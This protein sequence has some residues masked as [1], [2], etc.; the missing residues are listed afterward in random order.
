MAHIAEPCIEGGVAD[1]VTPAM[2]ARSS[3]AYARVLTE[4]H[5]LV[6]G[7]PV[8]FRAAN[9]PA[10]MAAMLGALRAGAVLAP[11][12]PQLSGAELS[13]ILTRINPGL[14]IADDPDDQALV[15]ALDA[16][17]ARPAVLALSGGGDSLQH[18]AAGLGGTSI[19]DV[20]M[21]RDDPALV[22]FTSGT[23]GRAKAVAHSHGDILTVADSFGRHIFRAGPGDIVTGTPSLA[24][25]Y[26]FG[27]LLVTPLAAGA[28]VAFPGGRGMDALRET[29]AGS[30]ATMLVTAPTAYRKLLETREPLHL[31]A[32]RRCFSAGE[33]LAAATRTDWRA[34][35]GLEIVDLLG[36]TEMLGPYVSAPEEEQRSGVVGR[37]VPG[38]ELKILGREGQALPSGEAGRLAVRGP[39]GGVYLDADM[40]T[41]NPVDG[42]TVTGDVCLMDSEGYVQCLGRADDIVVSSGYNIST[43]EVENV[44]VAHPDVAE[45]AATGLP[46]ALH[47]RVLAIAVAL[48]TPLSSPEE[49][50]AFLLNYLQARL[51]AFKLPRRFV[52][53]DVLP[54]T[55]SGKIRRAD[56]PGLF[57]HDVE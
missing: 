38:Y 11:T 23:T 16:V 44:L 12:V 33:P 46:D 45:C 35:T 15:T 36:S 25:A 56:L 9:S 10:L 21:H 7:M 39:T 18:R 31:P 50:Q 28:A 37:A 24:F 41:S 3:A 47:G 32:L 17:P 29:L 5:D 40:Q 49:M 4:D 20:R 19:S 43:V 30:G 14:V 55:A 53:V 52:F 2:L 6:P 13:E 34:R 1:R 42:W 26:G 8:L 57:S 51:A 22:L 27:L 54:R 48:H